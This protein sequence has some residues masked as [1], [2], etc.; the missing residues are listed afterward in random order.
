MIRGKARNCGWKTWFKMTLKIRRT[1]GAPEPA[2]SAVEGFRGV[3]N[4]G[5]HDRVR[6]EILNRCRSE[7]PRV[8]RVRQQAPPCSRHHRGRV[9]RTEQPAIGG[10]RIGPM[11]GGILQVCQFQ[12]EQEAPPCSRHHRGRVALQGRVLSLR[13]RPLGPV[14]AA[15]GSPPFTLRH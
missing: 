12:R 13:T 3:R 15:V 10:N 7:E 6:H 8:S 4:L 11:T 14:V 2:L 5:F 9:T 1:E